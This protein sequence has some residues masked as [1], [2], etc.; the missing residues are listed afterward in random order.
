VRKETKVLQELVV[1]PDTLEKLE[2]QVVSEL[3]EMMVLM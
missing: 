2:S 1:T 3:M